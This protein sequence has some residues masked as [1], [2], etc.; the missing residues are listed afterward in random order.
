LTSS[1][2]LYNESNVGRFAVGDFGPLLSSRFLLN[3]V[4]VIAKEVF[5]IVLEPSTICLGDEF[6]SLFA[7][8]DCVVNL[9]F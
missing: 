5:Y 3:T 8:I 9:L 6:M 7:E 2:W 4:G 1:S